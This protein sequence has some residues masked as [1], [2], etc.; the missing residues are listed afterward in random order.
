[1]AVLRVY[2]F[3]LRDVLSNGY[4]WFWSV[5]F[6]M[7]WLFMGAFVYGARFTLD[8]FSKQFP[9]DMPS[10]VIEEAWRESTLHYTASWYG[11]IALFSM[12]SITIGLTQYIF[13]STI[14][15]RY[16][17][18]YSK[19]SPL[20]FYTGFTLSAITSTAIYTLILL[21]TSILLYSYKFHG[22][23]TIISPKNM[24]GVV[25]TTITGGL[26]MYFLSSTIALLLIVLKK[27]KLLALASFV[28]Y[29]L[30]FG[31]GMAGL[32]A[33]GGKIHFSPFNLILLLNYHYYAEAT[34]ILDDPVTKM[35]Y[36]ALIGI[37]QAA[38]PLKLWLAL[39]GWTLLFATTTLILFRKQ[40]GISI[41]EIISL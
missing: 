37:G 8:E 24:L 5:F 14:P 35:W 26:L 6:M 33:T 34:I 18:K 20:K 29:V 31:L 28:P 15:I 32:I 4:F 12:S 10:P 39:I 36:N 7:F 27:P 30:S 23:K 2:K 17:T 22:F 13:Y 38:D 25:L 3:Y 11:S 9:I 1:M 40:R 19:A 16:L 41:E 21:I